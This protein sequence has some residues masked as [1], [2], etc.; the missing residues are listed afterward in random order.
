MSLNVYVLLFSLCFFFLFVSF[1]SDFLLLLLPVWFQIRKRK[2]GCDLGRWK[3]GEILG[4][5]LGE[6]K[7]GENILYEKIYIE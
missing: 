1:S 5:K 3:Y 2:E 6:K 4:E 7:P